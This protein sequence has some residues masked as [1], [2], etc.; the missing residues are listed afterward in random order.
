MGPRDARTFGYAV[1]FTKK[2]LTD[3]DRQRQDSELIGALSLFWSLLW[4]Y[5]PAEIMDEVQDALAGEYPYPTMGT[6]DVPPGKTVS[7]TLTVLTNL[8]GCGFTFKVDGID[9]NFGTTHRC[10]PEGIVTAGYQA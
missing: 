5:M 6:R 9:Y 8:I 4:A 10:P 3:A 7:F 2:R 1:S